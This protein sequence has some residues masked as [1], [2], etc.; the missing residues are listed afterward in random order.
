M[1]LLINILNIDVIILTGRIFNK[2]APLKYD[3][4]LIKMSSGLAPS[5]NACKVVFGSDRTDIA[6]LGGT[7]MAFFNFQAMK[8]TNFNTDKKLHI[9]WPTKKKIFKTVNTFLTKQIL[10]L[11]E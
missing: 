4:E 5:T 8:I 6:A 1:N 3:I 11:L 9:E 2:M 10:M 7:A